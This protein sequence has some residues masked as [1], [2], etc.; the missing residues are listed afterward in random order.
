MGA[1][2]V[3]L[4]A[5]GAVAGFALHLWLNRPGRAE[6]LWPLI[7]VNLCLWG[8][9]GFVVALQRETAAVCR[10]HSAHSAGVTFTAGYCVQVVNGA[11]VAIPLDL[12]P[13]A[14]HGVR[15]L[16]PRMWII[17]PAP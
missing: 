11:H 4:C 15:E 3:S 8:D 2:I 12:M 1:W 5:L 13:A 17:Q 16:D 7:L 14:A 6:V 10:A 9:I